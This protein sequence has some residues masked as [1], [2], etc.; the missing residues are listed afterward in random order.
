MPD[1][2]ARQRAVCPQ[3][4]EHESVVNGRIGLRLVFRCTR[5]GARFFR[6]HPSSPG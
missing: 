4:G 6:V 1:D 3:C 5:C 2:L